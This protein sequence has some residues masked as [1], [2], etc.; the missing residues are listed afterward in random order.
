MSSA[1]KYDPTLF[2]LERLEHVS[3]RT[4]EFRL[5]LSRLGS[6]ST[7]WAPVDSASFSRTE[8]YTIDANGTLV[9]DSETASVALSFW[10]N[11]DPGQLLY[12]SDRV[13]ASY[14]GTQVFRGQVDTTSITVEADP[15]RTDF[16]ATCVGAYWPF[17]NGSVC[18]HALPV[19]SP[20]T[21]IRRWLIVD[22][23]D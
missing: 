17:L 6:T 16:T 4:G 14:D 18:W 3:A 23:Y 2:V 22:N 10:G 9:Y 21:R 20:I 11:P 1:V 19:E 13:R 7:S 5:G 15:L 8:G 12:P